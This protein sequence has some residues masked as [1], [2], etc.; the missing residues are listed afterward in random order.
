MP[1]E[2]GPMLFPGPPPIL[3]TPQG[4]PCYTC[5]ALPVS[6]S[7]AP[8]RYHQAQQL[9]CLNHH[10]RS[11]QLDGDASRHCSN[12]SS[13]SDSSS[14]SHSPPDTPSMPNAPHW[15]NRGKYIV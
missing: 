13:A 3:T 2:A 14:T 12:S 5:I 1:L 4:T 11:L 15:D 7:A 9:A 8:T 10:M 6:S